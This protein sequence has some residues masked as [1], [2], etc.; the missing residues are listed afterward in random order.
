M[1]VDERASPRAQ[2]DG[3]SNEQAWNRLAIDHAIKGES[4]QIII[5]AAL[6]GRLDHTLGNLALLADARLSTIDIRLDDGL[7]EIVVCRDQVEVHGRSGDIVSLIPWQGAVS[8]I[9]TKGL[10][11]PLNKETLYPDKT[12]GISNEMLGATASISVGSGMLLVLHRR[13]S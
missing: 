9:Q 1:P 6:G 7:E 12:R 5:I 3:E 10:K 8:A 4:K 2:Q 13:Q 11:W